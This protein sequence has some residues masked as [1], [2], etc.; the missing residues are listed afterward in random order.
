MSPFRFP[1]I[2]IIPLV[3]FISMFKIDSCKHRF[4]LLF[5]ALLCNTSSS[6]NLVFHETTCW[7]WLVTYLENVESGT[8][9]PR[10]TQW[11]LDFS[12]WKHWSLLIYF[13]CCQFLFQVNLIPAVLDTTKSDLNIEKIWMFIVILKVFLTK[14]LKAI[15][16]HSI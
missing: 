3:S 5:P 12:H 8:S 10:W 11:L 6:W 13:T 16:R 14:N 15:S 2:W 4:S 1:D 9:C 7:E